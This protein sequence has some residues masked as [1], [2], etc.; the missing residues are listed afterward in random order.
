MSADRRQDHRCWRAPARSSSQLATIPHRRLED[1]PVLVTG[2]S[3]N[4]KDATIVAAVVALAH[5]FGIP[6][7]AE[8]VE[9]IAQADQLADLGCDLAQGYLWGE[10]Q[11]AD[12]VKTW[13]SREH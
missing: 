11:P 5:A 7:V 2:V 6:G 10:P 13:S 1:R 8:G 4:V 12:R 9:T 3:E